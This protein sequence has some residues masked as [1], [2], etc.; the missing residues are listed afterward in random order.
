MILRASL[1]AIDWNSN[2]NRE[3]RMDKFGKYLYR[4]KV[5]PHLVVVTVVILLYRQVDR[6]G[7]RTVLPVME[8]KNTSWQDK[9]S[10]SVISSMMTGDIPE[11]QVKLL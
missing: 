6:F 1:C 11:P 3:Q 5:W 2:V 4:E 8:P 7:N 9:I 10:M